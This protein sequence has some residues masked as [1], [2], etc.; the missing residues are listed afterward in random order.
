MIR[1]PGRCG[2]KIKKKKNLLQE[3]KFRWAQKFEQLLEHENLSVLLHI[4]HSVVA[5]LI[6]CFHS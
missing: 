3:E 6:C 1:L 5:Y 4:S 2:E